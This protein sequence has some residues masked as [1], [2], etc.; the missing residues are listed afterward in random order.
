[1]GSLRQFCLSVFEHRCTFRLYRSKFKVLPDSMSTLLSQCSNRRFLCIIERLTLNNKQLSGET[2]CLDEP[3]AI[4]TFRFK[5]CLVTGTCSPQCRF[6]ELFLI[7][8]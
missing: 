2:P 8:S 6:V 7:G 4:V 3:S 1:M 5:L